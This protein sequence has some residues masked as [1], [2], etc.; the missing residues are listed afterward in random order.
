MSNVVIIHA[1]EDA[2]PARALAEKLRQARLSVVIE[3]PPGEELRNAIKGAKVAIALWSPRSAGQSVLEEDA[4]FARTSTVLF[5][6]TMQ[7]AP[8]PAQFGGAQSINLTGWRGED[9]FPA[10]RALA[11]AVAER[12]G[13]PAPP[14]PSQQGA[15][16]FT[17]GRTGAGATQAGPRPAAEQRQVPPQ[18]SAPA[19]SPSPNPARA[20]ST[21]PV[22]ADEDAGPGGGRALLFGAI[23]LVAVVALGAGYF[24]MGQSQSGATRAADWNS[25]DSSDA[26]ALRAFIA[27]NPGEFKDEAK[28]ALAEL[29]ERSFEAASDEDSIEA[30][31]AFAREFPE[32]EHL[33]VARGRIAEL[34]TLAAEAAPP[35]PVTE[36]PPPAPAPDLVPPETTPAASGEAPPGETQLPAPNDAPLN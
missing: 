7:N 6:A 11:K 21:P 8:V 3:K 23:G 1:P 35:A 34:R 13:A 22:S 14:P 25:I 33:L 2:L 5:H 10:W 30:L 31:E 36:A 20:A 4:A 19:A 18:R 15:G 27:G 29:E 24:F 17:P 9:D 32:S 28:R 26:S 16:F 12:A